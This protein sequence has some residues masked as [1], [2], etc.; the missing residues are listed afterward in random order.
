MGSAV[1]APM[2]KAAVG[3]VGTD[4]HVDLAEG[5]LEIGGDELPYPLRLQVIGVVVAR[6]QHVGARHDAALDLGPEA[7]AARAAVEVLQVA[8]LL[9]AVAEAHTVI[10][11]QI[12]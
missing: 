4:E 2:R 11:R 8:R 3:L 1:L 5:A 6:R 10:A 12:R 9:A 7:L